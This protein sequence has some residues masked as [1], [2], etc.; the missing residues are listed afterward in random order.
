MFGSGASSYALLLLFALLSR[1]TDID[2]ALQPLVYRQNVPIGTGASATPSATKSASSV[3]VVQITSV[4]PTTVSIAPSATAQSTVSPI[5]SSPSNKASTASQDSTQSTQASVTGTSSD[6][7][8]SADSRSLTATDVSTQT[9]PGSTISSQHTGSVTQQV[10][11]TVVSVSGSSTLSIAKTTS[12]VVAANSAASSSGAPGLS[13]SNGSPASSGLPTSSKKIVGGVV[14]GIG[15]AILL[16]GLA[17]VAWRI[18]GKNKHSNDDDDDPMHPHSGSSG[19]E[20]TS[21]VSG[22]SGAFRSTLDQYHAPTQP[23]NTASNF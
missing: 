18:F 6:S 9:L 7:Q 2:R 1:A 3:A 13:G 16:G 17:I 22:N 11:T 4:P 8:T 12:K 10:V 21:S 19:R 14:G 5:T 23:V 20:K 15:G